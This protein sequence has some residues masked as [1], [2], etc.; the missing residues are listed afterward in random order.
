MIRKEESIVNC[1]YLRIYIQGCIILNQICGINS[2]STSNSH[3]CYSSTIKTYNNSLLSSSFLQCS[4]YIIGNTEYYFKNGN[5]FYEF[6]NI[7]QS[8]CLII[9]TIF[10]INPSSISKFYYSIISNNTG[11]QY[12]IGL[13]N[14]ATDQIFM[15]FSNLINSNIETNNHIRIR[16]TISIFE[17]TFIGCSNNIPLF[18]IAYEG[19][20]TISKC[21]FGG[22]QNIVTNANIVIQQSVVY[23]P[24]INAVLIPCFYTLLYLKT[25]NNCFSIHISRFSLYLIIFILI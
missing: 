21:F 14:S 6:S 18:G 3:F 23:F 16:G 15:S 13:G 5:I 20:S 17:C 10:L 22:G 2:T 8:Y 12:C 24:N 4:P 25:I 9:N 19:S 1:I 11:Y 7:S